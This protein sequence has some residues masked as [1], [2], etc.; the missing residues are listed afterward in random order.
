VAALE[1][2]S[3]ISTRIFT[4]ALAASVTVLASGCGKK[5]EKTQDIRR[6]RV[7]KLGA[8]SIGIAS[9]YSGEVRPENESR[10]GFRV[11]EQ[12]YFA[13][14]RCR[15]TASKTRTNSAAAGPQ[16]LQ[17][18]QAQAN[19]GFES[20]RK[21]CCLALESKL[22]CAAYMRSFCIQDG[23]ADEIFSRI[24]C[25]TLLFG[26]AGRDCFRQLSSR[27][28]PALVPVANPAGPAA[29]EFVRVLLQ[30]RH[31]PCAK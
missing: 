29:A 31:R 19:A 12:D 25:V 28:W 17:L 10:L 20:C 3:H 26:N 4:L 16:D 7:I 11:G 22:A 9:E 21:Q 23:L 30:F 2:T 15:K 18:A 1:K 14:G 24:S 13:Q 27:H 8:E 5:I 6:C